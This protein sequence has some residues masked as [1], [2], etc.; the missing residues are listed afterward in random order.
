MNLLIQY[1]QTINRA[2]DSNGAI[3]NVFIES[4]KDLGEMYNQ[5][6]KPVEETTQT[7]FNL[8]TKNDYFGKDCFLTDED[9][10]GL[11]AK[12]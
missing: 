9:F 4:C 1:F 10:L 5:I 6:T 7:V 8:F 12:K 3:G 2:D 11:A